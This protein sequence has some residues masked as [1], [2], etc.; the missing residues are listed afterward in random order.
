MA[1]GIDAGPSL[2]CDRACFFEREKNTEHE[3]MHRSVAL[4][5]TL[6][7]LFVLHSSPEFLRKRKAAS[8][9]DIRYALLISNRIEKV[10]ARRSMCFKIQKNPSS[11]IS[12]HTL[13]YVAH[14]I[15]PNNPFD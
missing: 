13:I 10:H 5:V 1:Y 7:R 3:G 2:T 15:Q 8:S 4:T 11:L 6:V 14:K 9:L 12:S